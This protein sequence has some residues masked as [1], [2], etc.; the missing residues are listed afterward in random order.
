MTGPV[1]PLG[2]WAFREGGSG[3]ECLIIA[4]KGWKGLVRINNPPSGIPWIWSD[5]RHLSEDSLTWG[6]WA[7][8]APSEGQRQT[9]TSA[10]PTEGVWKKGGRERRR[11]WMVLF[12]LWKEDNCILLWEQRSQGASASSGHVSRRQPMELRRFGSCASLLGQSRSGEEAAA[13]PH[14]QQCLED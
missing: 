9:G 14:A 1:P 11:W 13:N 7:S 6:F 10:K 3:F 8:S 4:K 5:Q 12:F 2:V